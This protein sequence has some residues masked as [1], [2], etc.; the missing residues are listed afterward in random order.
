[1]PMKMNRTGALVALCAAFLFGISTPFAKLL[2][3]GVDA[4]LLAGL[5]YFGAG[6]GLGLILM[7]RRLWHPS[8]PTNE[9]PLVRKDLPGLA[10]A[11]IF[12]GVL[13]PLLL[14]VGL[15]KTS[16]ANASLL[17]NSEAVL[18]A[19]L[20]WT[21]FREHFEK[22]IVWGMLA[23]VS[24]AIILSWTGRPE[25]NT[26]MGELLIALACL[27]WAVDN[28]VTRMISGGD[29][30]IIAC[31][32]GL[33]AGAVNITIGL[34]HGSTLPSSSTLGLAAL[35]GLMGYG[36]SLQLYVVAL[37]HIGTARTG[38]YFS[39]APF[40]GAAVALLLFR[41]P[42][43]ISFISAALL[44]A[45]GVWLHLT[46]RHVHEHIHENVAHEHKHMHEE[47]HQHQHGSEISLHEPH[48]HSHTHE[49][50]R[51][52]HGHYPDLHHRH[53]H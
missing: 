9:A 4:I 28:N 11:V 15:Q 35:V 39:V 45:L 47:H 48:S 16:A 25:G 17:L 29:P 24:G 33:I 20:A 6:I 42:L 22:R 52:T 13:G 34:S 23:I 41:T 27:A 7:V 8:R 14:M 40:A 46:E 19:L 32:K 36:L 53:P 21:V 12:G 5:L 18:T 1:M 30:Q 3:E 49:N 51:H 50:L 10:G 38:A 31:V 43:T 44:M 2:L 37:R 26:G